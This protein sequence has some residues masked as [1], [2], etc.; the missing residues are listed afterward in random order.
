MSDVKQRIKM[1][2][3]VIIKSI[4]FYKKRY[5]ILKSDQGWMNIKKPLWTKI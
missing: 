5:V 2:E 4:H 3:D 1:Y